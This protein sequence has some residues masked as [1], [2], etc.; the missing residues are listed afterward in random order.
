MV[1]TMSNQP[2]T[3]I[4]LHAM[5]RFVDRVDASLSHGHARVALY[6]MMQWSRKATEHM[7]HRLHVRVEW[8][9]D[10][11]ISECSYGT[12]LLAVKQGTLV[13]LWSVE[14][15]QQQ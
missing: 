15:Y 3:A 8:D 9:A 11:Y 6:R 10:Y 2:V 7:L 12:F 4:S 1:F 14:E 5:E 13:T